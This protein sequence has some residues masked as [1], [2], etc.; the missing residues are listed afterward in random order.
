MK[1]AGYSLIGIALLLALAWVIGPRLLVADSDMEEPRSE[2]HAARLGE[3]IYTAGGIGFFRTLSS[4]AAF[5][6]ADQEW[7]AC[8]DLPRSLHHVAMTAGEGRVYASGGYA[9]LPFSIDQDGAL[10]A[11]NPADGGWSE[12]SK[13]PHPIGQHTMS[14]RD[15]ALY[16]VGGDDGTA[17][18]ASLQRFEIATGEWSKLAPMPT[19]RHSHAV[20]Q[21]AEHLYVSGGRSDELGAQSVIVEAY[22]FAANEWQK[23]PD[24]PYPL[25]GHG[26]VVS[27]GRL[28][29]FGG[30]N[31][32]DNRIETGHYSLN[33]A[34]P[35]AGWREEATMPEPRH[36]FAAAE[37]DGSLWILA[38]GKRP[39]LQTPW[40][41]TG[42][43]L[44]VTLP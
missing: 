13:L 27:E 10:F 25:G 30:E 35:E 7:G 40:S 43:A 15:G 28:H 34:E 1:I 23:L 38:G 26:S 44:S 4:C 18:L 31:L 5:D 14:F 20:A 29:V 36:G 8:P 19:P 17:T 3:T 12:V 32:A 33:L 37:V 6:T 2:I 41:V 9:S 21:D 42:T 11:L 16:L 22:N 39:G 24:A